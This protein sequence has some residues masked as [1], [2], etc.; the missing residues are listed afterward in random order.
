MRKYGKYVVLFAMVL[1]GS[2]RLDYAAVGLQSLEE[3][4]DELELF[5]NG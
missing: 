4:P 1:F 3:T 2:D 5:H